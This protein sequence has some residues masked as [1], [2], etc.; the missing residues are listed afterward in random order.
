MLSVLRAPLKA[1]GEEQIESPRIDVVS[2]AKLRANTQLK[3]EIS[4]IVDSSYEDPTALLAREFGHCSTVYLKRNSLGELLCVFF[5]GERT[6]IVVDD[7]TYPALFLGLSAARQDIKDTGTIGAVYRKGIE[8]VIDWDELTG[9][10]TLLWWTT[11]TPRILLVNAKRML[12]SVEPQLDGTYSPWAGRVACA[13]RELLHVMPPAPDEHPFVLRG[14]AKAT[15]Y[16]EGERNRID[17]I[18]QHKQLTLFNR[19]GINEAEDRL[20]C[21]AFAPDRFRRLDKP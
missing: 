7:E 8:D 11:A 18:S 10:R 12:K 9:E 1:I 19:L 13:L 17:E 16:S 20:L 14:V 15:R 6:A 4:S 2:G 5:I 3:Q 21:F